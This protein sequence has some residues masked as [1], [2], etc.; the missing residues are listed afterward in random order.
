MNS[1]SQA[2]NS[3]SIQ[4]ENCEMSLNEKKNE[5]LNQSRN[6]FDYQPIIKHEITHLKNTE[7]EYFKGSAE[8]LVKGCLVYDSTIFS[9]GDSESKVEVS[10]QIFITSD[11]R[12]L[13]FIT[14][15]ETYFFNSGNKSHHR[16]NRIISEI[17]ELRLGEMFVV[18]NTLASRLHQKPLFNYNS[19]YVK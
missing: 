1:N 7:V 19:S 5:L 18:Y 6:A 12:F 4:K 14:T 17:Q 15:K 8:E 13:F 10:R 2:K 11:S 3:E 9:K 16:L